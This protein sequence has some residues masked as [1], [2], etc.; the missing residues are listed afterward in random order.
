MMLWLAL[1]AVA[2]V[3]EASDFRDHVDQARFFI[4]KRWYDD[5]E[6]ELK[7]AVALPD[8][9][10][11]PEAWFLL[12]QVR[13]EQANLAGAREAAGR[14]HS[15]SRDDQQLE[16]AATFSAFLNEQFGLVTVS[17]PHMGM[18]GHL[19]FELTSM[20]FDPDLKR[21]LERLNEQ[22]RKK[23]LLPVTVGVPAGTYEVNGQPVEVLAGRT[24]QVSLPVDA[25]DAGLLAV[26]VAQL[27]LSGGLTAWV[28]GDVPNLLPSPT[29]QLA[30]SQ[31][32]GP[33]VLGVVADWSPQS[34][35]TVEGARSFAPLSGTVGA[36]IG[37]ERNLRPI[38]VRPSIGYRY[39]TIPGFGLPC[40]APEATATC[41]PE[42]ESPDVWVY[43][44]GTAHIVFLEA[45]VDMLDRLRT[46]GWG[47]GVK[48]TV[49][50][51]VGA[52]PES[53]EAQ[54][55][56]STTLPYTVSEPVRFQAT[57]VRV[58]ANLSYAF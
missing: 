20:V 57:G 2:Q 40:L 55:P 17:A 47:L 10:L 11:D 42:T 5:A 44:V 15:M 45:H 8:G 22:V 54:Y 3:P 9:R 33:L 1:T 4:R 51:A 28:A 36:R 52:L 43:A 29:L 39:G 46:N 41:S 13:F 26:Q 37:V 12:A 7:A 48:A 23:T 38:V 50:H 16:Q 24:S 49:E 19:Q 56:D 25:L 18:E 53:S 35:R 6:R 31:P 27:E 14:A 34:F 30:Y 32:V 58:L 21:Y